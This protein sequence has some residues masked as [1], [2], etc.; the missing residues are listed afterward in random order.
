MSEV[1]LHLSPPVQEISQDDFQPSVEE[2]M[3]EVI[4]SKFSK[5]QKKYKFKQIIEIVKLRLIHT[6]L[7]KFIVKAKSQ[8]SYF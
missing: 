4:I 6:L 5:R 1:P 2:E 3:V 8:K 7:N